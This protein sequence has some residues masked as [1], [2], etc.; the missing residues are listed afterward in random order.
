MSSVTI[1]E[2]RSDPPVIRTGLGWSWRDEF[3]DFED[4]FGVLT[5][6]IYHFF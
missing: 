1:G 2:S 4:L 5:E 6:D 3:R